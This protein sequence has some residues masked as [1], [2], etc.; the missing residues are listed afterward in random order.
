MNKGILGAII[1][2][3]V[4]SRFMVSNSPGTDFVPFTDWSIFTGDTVMSIATAEWLYKKS[5]LSAEMHLW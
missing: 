4:S 3:I 5:D 2:D 1:G